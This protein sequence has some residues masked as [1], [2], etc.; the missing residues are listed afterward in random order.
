MFVQI[1][2]Y[3]VNDQEQQDSKNLWQY[4]KKKK[5]TPVT[6]LQTTIGSI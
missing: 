3:G 5:Y 4:K 6:N 1:S 2:I